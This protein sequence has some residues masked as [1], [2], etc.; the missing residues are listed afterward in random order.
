VATNPHENHPL[1]EIMP[2]VRCKLCRLELTD[3]TP[4]DGEH[5]TLIHSAHDGAS[6]AV[7]P[8]QSNCPLIGKQY[9]VDEG[10]IKQVE[11]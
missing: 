3:T 1:P 7:L 8:D 5:R 2:R 6:A 9:W 4:F 11:L 10:H